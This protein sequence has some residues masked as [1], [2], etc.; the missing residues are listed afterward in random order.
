[1]SSGSRS[2]KSSRISVS[3]APLAN[4]PN[5]STTRIRIPRIQGRPWHCSGR[6]VMRARRSCDISS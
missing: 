4:I 5:T 6:M 2:G 3:E 1:M